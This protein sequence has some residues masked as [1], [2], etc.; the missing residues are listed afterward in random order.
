M[1]LLISGA[2]G[3]IGNY[4]VKRLLAEGHEIFIVVRPSSKEIP[5]ENIGSYVFDGD[6]GKLIDFMRQNNFNGIIH[7]ASLFLAQHTTQDIKA[8][9]DSNVLFSTNLLE[10]ASKSEVPW[11]I[12]TGTFWQHFQNSTYSPVNLYAATKQAF[13]DIAKYY[14]ETSN[15]NFVTLKL[16]DTF[17]PNDTRKKIF[18][19]WM[20]IGKSGETLDMSKGEQIID[21]SY[22]ENVIDGYIYLIN[23]LS[24]DDSKKLQGRSFALKSNERMTLKNLAKLFEEV[25]NTKLNINWGKKK[26]RL[27]EVM[28]PW[29]NGETIPG[30]QPKISLRE[31]IKRTFNQSL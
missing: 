2:T 10:A 15:I 19:L 22:I 17:G 9:I 11:F 25:T 5:A 14:I 20:K 3:F 4:L 28:V 21:I 8:L 23:L 30:W 7:L 16:C 13:E 29:E 12:N 24:Q 31:G 1:K 27:R 6:T 26:Y 18:N